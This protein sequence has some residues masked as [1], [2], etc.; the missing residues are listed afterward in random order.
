MPYG[1][2]YSS[3]EIDLVG[4]VEEFGL[5]KYEA[6]AYITLVEKGNLG[7]SELAY[8]SNLPRT[9]IYSTLKKLQ[10]KG[11]LEL[12][13]HKPV[14]ASAVTPEVAF[15][16]IISFHERKLKN[17][18]RII[19]GLKKIEAMKNSIGSE[20]KRYT[21]I[22]PKF[23]DQKV[24]NLI[25]A[26]KTVI[27]AMLDSWGL[28]ILSRCQDALKSAISRGVTIK[29]L[30]GS[31]SLGNPYL[32]SLPKGPDI[33]FHQ[34]CDSVLSIDSSRIISIDSTNGKGVVTSFFDTVGELNDRLFVERWEKALKVNSLVGLDQ[35]TLVDALRFK[36]MAE[37]KL[38][39]QI[40][41]DM[42]KAILVF[43][44]S[45]TKINPNNV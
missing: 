4:N 35:E 10:K 29:L 12:S 42:A 25:L 15:T 26:S 30:I 22:D 40:S 14:I 44:S 16:E 33:R 6:R 28:N 24:S 32:H 1:R 41:Q 39:D 5:S 34:F 20:E 7:A 17:M 21:V 43:P 27:N 45:F 31:Q 3:S 2:N 11:L 36:R 18:K 23:V 19:N 37:E 8:Y 13:N 9:K 38:S